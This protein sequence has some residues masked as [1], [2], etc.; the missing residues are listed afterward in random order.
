MK[1]NK[2]LAK[3][4]LEE[5]IVNLIKKLETKPKSKI[6]KIIKKT[7]PKI[8][9]EIKTKKTKQTQDTYSFASREYQSLEKAGVYSQLI[10]N[11][12]VGFIY[13]SNVRE[14]KEFY[15]QQAELT[16]SDQL[17]GKN[18][19]SSET[20][21][22]YAR[23][24]TLNFLFGADVNDISIE[25]KERMKNNLYDQAQNILYQAKVSLLGFGTFKT[26]HAPL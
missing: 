12:F 20:M 18:L 21:D 8:E 19:A 25:E 3:L 2:R 14:N 26:M 17:G 11:Q 9:I 7:K 16:I 23:K 6:E 13:K 5:H 22:N 24:F 15:S 4:I 10:I 1:Q